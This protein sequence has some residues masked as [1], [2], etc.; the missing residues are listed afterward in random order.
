MLIRPT[1]RIGSMMRELA[2]GLKRQQ[3][4]LTMESCRQLV[5]DAPITKYHKQ[6]THL[7]ASQP[8]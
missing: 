4:D 3:G 6:F 2:Q 8:C 5:T 1:E 7:A